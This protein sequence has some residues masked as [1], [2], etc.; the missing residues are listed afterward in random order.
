MAPPR[1]DK[2]ARLIGAAARVVYKQ[3]FGSTT[4]SDIARE[5]EV[6]LGNV[7]YYFKTKEAIGDALIAHR[8]EGFLALRAQ[9]D[10]LPEARER[11]YA[12]VQMTLNNQARLACF[13]CPI[14]TLTSELHKH[15]GPLASQAS[16]L[17]GGL[18][19]WLQTQFET[20]GYPSERSRHEAIHLL[21]VLE[22]ATLL[23]HSFQSTEYVETECQ[24][25]MRWIDLL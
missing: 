25:L 19:D 8:K 1:S 9:W 6:P 22:G 15:G 11:L 3:G 24:R 10:A 7:Y 13:G 4:L 14:G 23:T 2:R 17:F 21:T 18:L 20:L 5:A 12:C 16:A